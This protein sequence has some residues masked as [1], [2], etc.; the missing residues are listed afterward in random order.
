[1]FLGWSLNK[2]DRMPEYTAG[3]DITGI[4]LDYGNNV[5]ITLYAIYSDPITY[6]ISLD[7]K[8][9]TPAPKQSYD[10]R[11]SMNANGTYSG[12][13][14]VSSTAFKLPKLV[15][16]GYKFNGWYDLNTGKKLSSIAKGSYGDKSLYASFTPVAYKITYTLNKGS[17]PKDEVYDRTFSIET[18]EIVLP[19][20]YRKGYTFDG[21][22]LDKAL[23]QQALSIHDLP[24]KNVK[25][26]AGWIPN[27]Y[28]ITFR[29]WD[30]ADITLDGYRYDVSYKLDSDIFDV[31]GKAVSKW[32]YSYVDAKGK[33]VTKTIAGNASVKNLVSQDGGNIVLSVVTSVNKTTGIETE[34]WKDV[35]YTIKYSL[36]KGTTNGSKNPTKYSY[37]EE[38]NVYMIKNPVRSD[39]YFLYWTYEDR[40]GE[41]QLIYPV[42]YDGT[43]N[44]YS[45]LP[46]GM[47]QNIVLVA[48]F[49]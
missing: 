6:T 38:E 21:W 3:D 42:N 4:N 13:Y 7:P 16:D 36:P 9:G 28:S 35:T 2:D 27:V 33:T 44:G 31:P 37:T 39:C 12:T 47:H 29:S 22:Y 30:H 23:T 48:Y 15:K 46:A 32:T 1:A 41:T 11:L 45:Y 19:E 49:E 14:D 34:L 10:S 24:M 17:I 18:E 8:G 25:L 5:T 40:E 43:K 26:Y 20:P